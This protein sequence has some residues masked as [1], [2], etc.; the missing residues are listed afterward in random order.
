MGTWFR[1]YRNNDAGIAGR[2][3]GTIHRLVIAAYASSLSSIM[4]TLSTSE[5]PMSVILEFISTHRAGTRSERLMMA[6]V[7]LLRLLHGPA[8]ALA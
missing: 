3:R 4:T 2:R 7:P 6:W 1:R 8:A 5:T